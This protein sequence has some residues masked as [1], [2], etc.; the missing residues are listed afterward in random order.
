M[1]NKKDSPGV[2]IP[3][4]LFYVLVFLLSFILQGSFT[5][6]RF[7][8]FHSRPANILGLIVILT[9]FLFVVP[10]IR[11]FFKSKTSMVP[12]KPASSLQTTGIYSVSRNPMYL[13]LMFEYLGMAF[14]FGNWWTLFL[15]PVLIGLIYYFVIRPEESYLQRAFGSDYIEYTKKV[16]RWI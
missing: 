1:K 10:A 9:G 7:Y 12:I 11:Q 2:F 8:F 6:K 14:I 16:R 13:G 3:P 15:I 4:P 5:I